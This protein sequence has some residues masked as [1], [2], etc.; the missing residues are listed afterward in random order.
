MKWLPPSWH[1][2]ESTCKVTLTPNS[3]EVFDA[4]P[5]SVPISEKSSDYKESQSSLHE[6][7][8]VSERASYHSDTSTSPEALELTE[9]LVDSMPKQQKWGIRFRGKRK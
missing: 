2:T 4:A 5:A 1:S 7:D 9:Q 8:T 3:L 6:S